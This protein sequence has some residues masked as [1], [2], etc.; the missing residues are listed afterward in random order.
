MSQAPTVIFENGENAPDH[1]EGNRMN[2]IPLILRQI[3]RLLRQNT[4][5]LQ[6]ILEYVQAHKKVTLCHFSYL[7][8]MSEDF[9]EKHSEELH[10]FLHQITLDSIN[11][12]K[13]FIVESTIIMHT[14]HRLDDF[15]KKVAT[16][17]RNANDNSRVFINEPEYKCF[18]EI[19]Q[20]HEHQVFLMTTLQESVISNYDSFVDVLLHNTEEVEGYLDEL[21]INLGFEERSMPFT[22]FYLG[23]EDI[24][25]TEYNYNITNNFISANLMHDQ[26]NLNLRIPEDVETIAQRWH[27]QN[28]RFMRILCQRYETCIVKERQIKIITRKQTEFPPCFGL[29]GP[30][31]HGCIVLE[32]NIVKFGSTCIDESIQNYTEASVEIINPGF[33]QHFDWNLANFEDLKNLYSVIRDQVL[34]LGSELIDIVN[35]RLIAAEFL[36]SNVIRLN[37]I[38][39]HIIQDSNNAKR[40][41]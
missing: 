26:S 27:L 11:E 38:L 3:Q 16:K 22:K 37:R 35:N 1:V 40:F 6:Q 5:K 28:E 7:H 10:N 25:L 32:L 9:L 18:K 12:D 17:E 13:T 20:M 15:V 41:I 14:R 30:S 23:N 29:N 24:I 33:Q 4:E 31:Q 34:Q 36:A 2:K 8:R 19:Q 39:Y 21:M